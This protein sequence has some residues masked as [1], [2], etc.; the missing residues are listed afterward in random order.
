MNFL[1]TLILLFFCTVVLSSI[2][3]VFMNLASSI[4]YQFIRF[5]NRIST[6]YIIAL[7]ILTFIHAYIFLSFLS[8]L[9][10]L[11]YACTTTGIVFKFLIWTFALVLGFFVSFMAYFRSKHRL[12]DLKVQKYEPFHVNALA[13]NASISSLGFII[14]SIYPKV[15]SWGWPWVEN[16]FN[17]II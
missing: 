2:S 1:I 14:L 12:N 7:M 11:C 6:K 3:V 4:I 15:I 5:E 8:V 10:L 13:L 17:S 9:I 16:I